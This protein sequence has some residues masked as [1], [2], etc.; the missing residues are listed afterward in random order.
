MVALVAQLAVGIVLDDRHAVPVSQFHQ[1]HAPL[2]AEGGPA[3][4]LEIGQNVNELRSDTQ[5]FFKLVHDHPVFVGRYRDILCAIGIPGLKRS[6]VGGQ[7]DHDVVTLIDE[8]PSEQ[9]E[10][11]LRAGGDQDIISSDVDAIAHRVTGDHLAQRTIAIGGSILQRL[12]PIGIQ[13]SDAGFFKLL[14]RKDF[15]RGQSSCKGDDVR[16]LGQFEQFT[17]HR[18]PHPRRA[19]CIAVFPGC[20]QHSFSL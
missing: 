15:R 8:Q 3:R 7:F 17:D 5:R 18:T 6:Q 2:Q 13:N 10:R 12:R 11:L 20:L 16:L 19:V 1:P 14:D 9:I 4:V